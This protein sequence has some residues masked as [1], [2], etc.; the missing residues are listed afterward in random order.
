MDRN[1]V[2]ATSGVPK[3][4]TRAEDSEEENS[5]QDGD[6]CTVRRTVVKALTY[7]N[8]MMNNEFR[9]VKCIF[10]SLTKPYSIQL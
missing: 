8:H 6:G 7:P 1:V 4:N 3:N 2:A 10:L 5:R 9:A